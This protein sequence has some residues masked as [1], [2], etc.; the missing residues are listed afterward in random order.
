MPSLVK[1]E[2][3]FEVSALILAHCER[4]IKA[5]KLVCRQDDRFFT[6]TA[7]GKKTFLYSKPLYTRVLCEDK[8]VAYC[9]E[10]KLFS[11][12]IYQY[13]WGATGLKWGDEVVELKALLKVDS[14]NLLLTASLARIYSAI[15]K[16]LAE[17]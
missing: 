12:R 3:P 14:D 13:G 11:S 10:Q 16:Q 7:T 8:I 1:I 2:V 9:V 4:Y 6:Y 17:A 5:D 15:Y